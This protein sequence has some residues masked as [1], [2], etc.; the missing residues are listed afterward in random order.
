MIDSLICPFEVYDISTNTP[1]VI[2]RTYGRSIQ[3]R[4]LPSGLERF[5]P[6]A[7]DDSLPKSPINPPSAS[8][9]SPAVDSSQRGGTGLPADLLLPL[10]ESLR[11]D[12]AEIRA[13]LADAPVRM[14]GAS[15]LI[16]YEADWARA[17]EGLRTLEELTA[18]ADGEEEEDAEDEDD[19][20]DDDDDD[21]SV[22]MTFPYAAK[23][24]DFA[25]TRIVSGGD[26]DTGVLLG[27]DNLLQL[28]D[29]RIAQVR[30]IAADQC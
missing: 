8:T 28:L 27:L 3:A 15:L 29:G 19:E 20:Q 5:F 13:A 21:D 17:R 1:I 22:A 11:E 25:H 10:L 18:R 6:L 14:V 12:I 23:L 7:S 26:T 4:E 9:Q 30:G 2:P 16:V 24:I